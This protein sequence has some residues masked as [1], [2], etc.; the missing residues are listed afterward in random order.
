MVNSGN[1]MSGQEWISRYGTPCHLI[2]DRGVQFMSQKLKEFPK[3]C[4]IQLKHTTSY[5]PQSNGKIER[6]HRTLKTAIS[7]HN[8]IRWTERLPSAL[9]GLRSSKYGSSDFSIAQMVFGKTIR[10]PGEFSQDSQQTGDRE[11]LIKTLQK[12]MS[13]LQPMKSRINRNPNVFIH[14]DLQSCSHVF[15][16]KD[17]VKK[18]LEPAYED[19]FKV[20]K[21]TVKYFTL[22]VKGEEDNISL[23][24]LKPAYLLKELYPKDDDR[25]Q[26]PGIQQDL[27]PS[28]A[29][30]QRVHFEEPQRTRSGRTF[31]VYIGMQTGDSESNI[32]PRGKLRKTNFGD[33][34][35]IY[36]RKEQTKNGKQKISLMG[37][38]Q[39][40]KI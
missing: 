20:L 13:S 19:P 24:C 29:R 21:R 22:M 34:T 9:L 7:S 16:R 1:L 32:L 39:S 8:Y 23:D 5:H 17:R 11:D 36:F 6:F 31:R 40:S 26:Q 30:T 33:K 35:A 10:L 4:G 12:D 37:N 25:R 27:Q 15:I 38:L 18:P 28:K 3:M 14:K 2:T